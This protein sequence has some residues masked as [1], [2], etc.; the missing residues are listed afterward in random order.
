MMQ[1]SAEHAQLQPHSFIILTQGPAL[2]LQEEEEEEEERRQNEEKKLFLKSAD[3]RPHSWKSFN[4]YMCI[5]FINMIPRQTTFKN[6]VC[7]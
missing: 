4:I 1:N 7:E 5:P 3:S 6:G 2:T